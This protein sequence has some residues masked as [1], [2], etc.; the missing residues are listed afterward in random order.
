M[1]HQLTIQSGARHRS[2]MSL[3]GSGS[4]SLLLRGL[5]K[6]NLIHHLAHTGGKATLTRIGRAWKPAFD[7]LP[8]GG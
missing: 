6:A 1:P 3:R 4:L 2:E 7:W 5:I 8:S